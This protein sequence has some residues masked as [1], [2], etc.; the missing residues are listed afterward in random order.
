M[1]YDLRH[2][3][4]QVQFLSIRNMAAELLRMALKPIERCSR[5]VQGS[6]EV[7]MD[8]TIVV[9]CR[10]GSKVYLN[11]FLTKSGVEGEVDSP[12][13]FPILVHFSQDL[14]YGCVFLGY[15]IHSHF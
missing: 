9:G 13:D 14:R 12:I 15:H 1:S 11:G 2:R 8:S 4:D 5:V 7:R 3:G 6:I 10:I